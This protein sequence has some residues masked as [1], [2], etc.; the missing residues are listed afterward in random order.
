MKSG[1]LIKIIQ[2][3]GL[4]SFPIILC[5]FIL[6]ITLRTGKFDGEENPT[7]I[8]I[9]ERFKAI[10]RQITIQNKEIA[11]HNTFGFNDRERSRHKA[12]KTSRIAILG[13]SFVWG[14]GVPYD[15]IWSHKFEKIISGRFQNIEVLSWGIS[16][17][18]T[19]DE[20]NFLKT[21]GKDYEIDLL[22]VDFTTN[23]PDLGTYPQQYLN[24]GKSLWFAPVK[25]FFPLSSQFIRSYVNNIYERYLTKDF[26]YFNWENKLYEKENLKNYAKVLSD[27]SVICRELNIDLLFVLTP[28]NYHEVFKE[29]FE[30][31]TPLLTEA[32]IQ[33]LDLYPAVY[34]KLHN[35]PHRH[36][37]ANP[38]DAH[39]GDLVTEIYKNEVFNFL[40]STGTLELLNNKYK[41]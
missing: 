6:E 10:N 13:D 11:K 7:P 24:F 32:R 30:K 5:L 25:K 33:Y 8:W 15:V 9:P 17:W 2:Y 26:G 41:K 3:T 16:G 20:L 21:H 23:D 19:L 29:K 12:P 37:W 27:F 39:P 31:I 36:L 34:Q 40:D 4:I 14:G 1:F 22:I 28:N 38:A 18:S 35:I